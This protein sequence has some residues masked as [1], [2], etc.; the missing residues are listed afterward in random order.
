MYGGRFV[1]IGSYLKGGLMQDK[2]DVKRVTVNVSGQLHRTLGVSF[3]QKK[4]GSHEP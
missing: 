1:F 2:A 3:W 4:G